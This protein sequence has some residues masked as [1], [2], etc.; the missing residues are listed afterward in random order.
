MDIESMIALG[1]VLEAHANRHW[2]RGRIA[3]AEAEKAVAE[4][5]ERSMGRYEDCGDF[6]REQTAKAVTV[7]SE[8]ETAKRQAEKHFK[9][10][11]EGFRE[12]YPQLAGF[13]EER[14]Q[15]QSE[16]HAEQHRQAV[17]AQAT[18]SG[19]KK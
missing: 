19:R 11:R 17:A 8:R 10:L 18:S 14:L 15:L 5:E 3:P 2:A 16:Q 13:M 6:Y 12:T 4:K 7:I 1:R 9:A